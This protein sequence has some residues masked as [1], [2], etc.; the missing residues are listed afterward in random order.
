MRKLALVLALLPMTACSTVGG[1]ITQEQSD[2]GIQSVAAL[3]SRYESGAYWT[4]LR[5][6]A[7]GRSN[8]WKRDF[9]Q[10]GDFFDRHL[11]NYDANDPYV[12]YPTDNTRVGHTGRTG[13]A[14]VSALPVAGDIWDWF[15]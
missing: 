2:R 6:S 3:S 13:L 7:D 4:S 14:M 10:I 11:W 9:G 8:A 15:R 12:N 1:G 5:Q